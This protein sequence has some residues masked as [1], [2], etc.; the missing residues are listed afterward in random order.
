MDSFKLYG[1][2]DAFVWDARNPVSA[3]FAYPIGPYKERLFLD[4]ELAEFLDVRE[5]RHLANRANLSGIMA[6]RMRGERTPILPPLPAPER[7]TTARAPNAS[8]RE[9]SPSGSERRLRDSDEAPARDSSGSSA[10]P[11]F[12]KLPP[13]G[14]SLPLLDFGPSD[15]KPS[16]G[17][18]SS[19]GSDQF[20]RN[21]RGLD[22]IGERSREGSTFTPITSPQQSV[23]V[24]DSNQPGALQT[25]SRFGIVNDEAVSPM[26]QA[27]NAQP[28]RQSS[29]VLPDDNR[30]VH[31]NRQ[32]S[33]AS[34]QAAAP[35]PPAPNAFESRHVET[36]APQSMPPSQSQPQPLPQYRQS[37]PQSQPQPPFQADA[38]SQVQAQPMS[39]DSSRSS[40]AG[41]AD[42]VPVQTAPN[43]NGP[44]QAAAV[45]APALAAAAAPPI[46]ASRY[47]AA[48]VQQQL[49]QPQQQQLSQQESAPSGPPAPAPSGRG[50]ESNVAANTSNAAT[51]NNKRESDSFANYDESVL[52]YMQSIS[53]QL[54]A[55]AAT[56]KAAPPSPTTP[57]AS[58]P[59]SEAAQLA[60]A[61]R[62]PPVAESVN[63]H[64]TAT[65][66]QS[67]RSP[68]VRNAAL[69]AHAGEDSIGDDALAV[70][71]FL[72]RPPSPVV[73]TQRTSPRSVRDVTLDGAGVAQG[74]ASA[75]GPDAASAYAPAPAAQQPVHPS[76]TSYPSSFGSNKRAIERKT[77]AQ[78]QAQAHQ[79]ALHKPGR[80]TNRKPP[81]GKGAHAWGEESSEEEEEEEEE[82]EDED[83]AGQVPVRSRQPSAT[84]SDV[85][86]DGRRS[87]RA[88]PSA[89]G[90]GTNATASVADMEEFQRAAM[91]AGLAPPNPMYA[92]QGEYGQYMDGSGPTGSSRPGSAGQSGNGHA[93]SRPISSH[94]S[95]MQQRPSVFNNLLGAGH[96][97]DSRSNTPPSQGGP[98]RQTFVQLGSEDQPGAMTT[99]FTPHG[100]LQA[101]AQD[102][103]ERSAKAQEQEAR[104]MGGHLVNVPNKPPPPQAGLL[105]AI[106]AHERDRRAPGGLGATLTERER[107]RVAAERRQ[108]EEDMQRS[109]TMQQIMGGPGGAGGFMGGLNPYQYQMWQQQQQQ[110]QMMMM[111]ATGGGM[112]MNGMNPMMG[113]GGYA[114][115][116]FGHMGGQMDPMMAQRQAM[117]AA[118]QAYF[119][120]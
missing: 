72:E 116:A 57:A 35:A 76:P 119:Q 108:R 112:G 6:A 48:N 7:T 113:M 68:P 16:A 24:H 115:S 86:G 25:T 14:G 99:V 61:S 96:G 32:F 40:G 19:M 5:E 117:Q 78:L 9:G 106:S 28:S 30:S 84:G 102:K 26:S 31:S 81:T 1:R 101:G 73:K 47:T 66:G 38:R 89:P 39:A 12:S 118:Q 60:D 120:A 95:L 105:G 109:Q 88:L 21:S 41:P 79:E 37:Q 94:P 10:E 74:G 15:D 69:P 51:T 114:P 111:M 59:G 63:S 75:A 110:Q 91:A 17:L 93:G 49:Q 100:L 87:T 65:Q 52:F 90:G 92:Q 67:V 44:V 54:P 13:L 33:Q 64:S 36:S 71:S 45:A 29:G 104:A 53:D 18:E 3:F 23:S 70:Y 8:A 34:Q 85:N 98:G 20:S 58:P 2:P 77:A 42:F 50:A 103:A 11:S 97:D 107:E 82:E 83:E 46:A 4:R 55:P 62:A 27:P 80:P 22:A 43:G 56:P